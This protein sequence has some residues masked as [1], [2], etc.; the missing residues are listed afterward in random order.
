MP[1]TEDDPT[2]TVST[3]ITPAYV[4]FAVTS[5]SVT[6]SPE[7]DASTIEEVV[8][9][10][11][12]PPKSGRALNWLPMGGAKQDNNSTSSG[13]INYVTTISTPTATKP[14]M[15]LSDVSMDDDD[16]DDGDSF[17]A[18]QEVAAT[19][20]SEATTMSTTTTSRSA[21]S[22][23]IRHEARLL[24]SQSSSAS[25]STE[26]NT[27]P[28]SIDT[29]GECSDNG[30]TYKVSNTHTYSHA[31]SFIWWQLDHNFHNFIHKIYLRRLRSCAPETR[32]LSYKY[33]SCGTLLCCCI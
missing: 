22:T 21:S 1:V 27:S 4:P 28:S 8:P 10:S 29:P 11:V 25:V 16:D 3:T 23:T 9:K 33:F 32:L 30:I 18:Q 5:S 19:S 26:G 6:G 31:Q 13:A 17:S 20:S 24:E 7:A 12:V 14:K 2:T 15:D